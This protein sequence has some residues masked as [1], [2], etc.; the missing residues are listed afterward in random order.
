[1]SSHILMATV[2]AIALSTPAWADDP[3]EVP[4]DACLEAILFDPAEAPIDREMKT[5]WLE[6]VEAVFQE[7]P[8]AAAEALRSGLGGQA[9]G[10]IGFAATE[11]GPAPTNARFAAD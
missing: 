8:V 3:A 11:H 4:S 9:A 2:T 7:N 6:H 10:R 5:L 1:M